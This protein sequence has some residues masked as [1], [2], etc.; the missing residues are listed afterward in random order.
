[1]AD[2]TYPMPAHG[3]TCFHCGENFTTPG[4]ARN[5]FGFDPSSDPACIIKL[6][7]ERGLVGQIRKCE[8]EISSLVFALHNESA[9]GIK[10]MRAQTSRH[11]A[12]ITTAEEAGYEKGLSDGR[13]MEAKRVAILR[14]ALAWHGDPARMATTR[15]E[16]QQEVDDA[17]EWVKANFEDGR[18]SFPSFAFINVPQGPDWK[19]LCEGVLGQF[20]HAGCTCTFPDD[21]CCSYR[22]ATAAIRN[23]AK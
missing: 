21:D 3:W 8:D 22:R 19:S 12:Q 10:A 16:W 20:D 11:A 7:A 14:R 18:P 15:E 23:E 4:G 1:M 5:H 13:A 2:D 17:I 6:G 9:E